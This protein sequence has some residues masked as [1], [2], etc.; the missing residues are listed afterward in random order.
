MSSEEICALL[1]SIDSDEGEDIDNLMND[2]D[3][4]FVDRSVVE[5]LESDISDA[6]I[7]EED[8]SNVSNF[9]QTKK[10]IEAVVKIA[11]PDPKPVDNDDAPLS[12]RGSK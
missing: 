5:T 7:H 12:N 9:I 1:D 2:S 11:K 10:P 4:E 6:V 8:V 3:T